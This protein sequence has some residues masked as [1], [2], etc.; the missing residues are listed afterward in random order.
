VPDAEFFSA[1]KYKINKANFFK[2]T[3]KN[4]ILTT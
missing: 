2:T 3:H 1:E 4:S